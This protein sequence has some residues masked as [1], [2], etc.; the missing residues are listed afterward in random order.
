MNTLLLTLVA[1]GFIATVAALVTGVASMAHGGPFDDRH[2]NQLMTARVAAQ[3][4]TV[5]LVIV[6]LLVVSL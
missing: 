4:V 5:L 2:S 6:A 1:L 3:L